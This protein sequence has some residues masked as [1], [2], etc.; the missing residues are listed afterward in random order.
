MAHFFVIESWVG[1]VGLILPHKLQHYGHTY[2]FV[3]RNPGH[4]NAWFQ[5]KSRF[6]KEKLKG[7][8]PLI[9]MAGE[10]LILE[11]NNDIELIEQLEKY[12]KINCVDGVF[13]CCD[14]YLETVANVAEKLNL[15]GPSPGAV[16]TERQKGLMREAIRNAGLPGPEFIVTGNVREAIKFA[17]CYGFPVVVKAVDLCASEH[18]FAAETPEA[19]EQAFLRV[20]QETTNIRGQ[21]RSAEVLV[22]EFLEGEEFSVETISF[23]GETFV[24]GVTD[25]SLV[26][27]PAFIESGVMHPA[28]LSKEKQQLLRGFVKDILAAI[29]YA[30]G[31]SHT[32]AKLT[33]IGPR[34]VE[35]NPRMGGSYLF[36][37][38]EMVTGID[39]FQVLFDLAQGRRPRMQVRQTKVRSAAL[40]F[41]LPPR[42][43]TI[44]RIRNVEQ[45]KADRQIHRVVIDDI[46]G[47]TVRSPR[48]NNDFIGHIIA[49]DPSGYGARAK[50][51]SAAA[52]LEIVMAS[53]QAISLCCEI[54]QIYHKLTD[55]ES[56][57]P[58]EM[59]NRLFSRLVELAISGKQGLADLVLSN[60]RIEAI[61]SNLWHVCSL[62]EYCLEAFWTRRILN[63]QNAP[64]E[65]LEFPYYSNYKL[66]TQLEHYSIHAV[67]Q[68]PIRHILFAGSGPLPLSSIVLARNYQLSIDN[69][70]LNPEAY[71]LSLHGWD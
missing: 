68:S 51:E 49:I 7:K 29:N 43:G 39:N 54:E 10:V 5:Q 19:L 20:I 18:V 1:A 4:Y 28:N 65:L 62:G 67:T 16:R 56:L 40:H 31:L 38:I 47:K 46:I 44:D 63:A 26:G 23:Q 14:Y 21:K 66:L 3:S 8:H 17:R 55:L 32:E 11:T 13:T 50:A 2:T 59:V 60:P 42:G 37:L 71:Q 34:I 57:Q 64:H 45:V 53:S 30:H 6:T 70:D 35:I 27:Y 9:E 24:V 69:L 15:H 48:D 58:N 12:R 25:K 41:L 61:Q 52:K 22:E 36:E 33:P